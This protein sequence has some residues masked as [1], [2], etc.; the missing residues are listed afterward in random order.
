MVR[1]IN[2]AF[3][4]KTQEICGELCLNDAKIYAGLSQSQDAFRTII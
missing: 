3:S 2:N 4:H 1:K